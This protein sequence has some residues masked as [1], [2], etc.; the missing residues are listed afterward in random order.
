MYTPYDSQSLQSYG[1]RLQE[2]SRR[3]RTH[4]SPA[5]ERGL[6]PRLRSLVHRRSA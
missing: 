4:R 1:L 5:A 3:Q 2:E 6:T